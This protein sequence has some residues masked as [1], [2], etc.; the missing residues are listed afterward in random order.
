MAKTEGYS[1]TP[2]AKKLGLKAGFALWLI[3]TP[4]HYHDLFH[5]LPD[6][7]LFLDEAHS[8]EADFIHWFCRSE[9]ELV[10]RAEKIKRALKKSGM[11]WVSWPKGSSSITT[12]LKREPIREHLLAVGL[13][14]TK[15]CAVDSDWSG[16][17]FMYRLKDR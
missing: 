10:K 8:E 13:V 17:K 14:D 7:L 15:V 16:L 3:D 6:G 11:L 2:L 12:D 1:G 4:D 5:S 9:E